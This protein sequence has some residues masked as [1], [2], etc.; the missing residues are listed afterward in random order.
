[1]PRAC[2]C[3]SCAPPEMKRTPL[4]RAGTS[5]GLVPVKK[6][7]ASRLMASRRGQCPSGVR[8]TG[9]GLAP[10]LENAAQCLT[11][12][13]S[14]SRPARRDVAS[15]YWCAIIISRSYVQLSSVSPPQSAVLHVDDFD[16]DSGDWAVMMP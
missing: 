6:A 14:Y 16:V 2:R 10:A 13:H 12:R 1:M 8:G 9:G 3:V 5:M 15:P 4:P 7:A 11:C